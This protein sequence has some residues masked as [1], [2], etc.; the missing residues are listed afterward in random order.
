MAEV[1]FVYN[2]VTQKALDTDATARIELTKN[3][4][5]PKHP[6]ICLRKKKLFKWK[7]LRDECPVCADERK[8]EKKGKAA[9]A[10]LSISC[11]TFAG[12]GMGIGGGESRKEDNPH[13]QGCKK[14]NTSDWKKSLSSELG[15]C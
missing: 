10:F 8:H 11:G 9:F 3:G 7:P 15:Q 14:S 12:L 6:D 2:T 4:V 13:W 1:S 5:C